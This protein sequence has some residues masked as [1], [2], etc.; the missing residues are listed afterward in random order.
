MDSDSSH[1]IGVTVEAEAWHA[2]VTDPEGLSRRV[3]GMVLSEEA[4]AGEV[5]VLLADDARLRA[6]NRDWRAVDRPT[7]VLSFP[8]DDPPGFRPAEGG[9]PRVLGDI[10]VALETTRSEAAAESKALAH[11]LSHLLVHGTLHLLGYDHEEE[12][13]A[14]AMESR[15]T[16]L[17]AGLGIADPYRPEAVP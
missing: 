11:H 10:A 4:I 13:A 5:G 14:E 17:L 3:V 15:E 2:A 9:P 6:L 12:E 7:N 16:E 1:S 8:A